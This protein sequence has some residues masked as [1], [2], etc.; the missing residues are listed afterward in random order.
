V[1]LVVWLADLDLDL[2]TGRGKKRVLASIGDDVGSKQTFAIF[3]SLTYKYGTVLKSVIPR[4]PL[5]T[6]FAWSCTGQHER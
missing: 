4:F 6:G 3:I 5:G 1:H 2:R